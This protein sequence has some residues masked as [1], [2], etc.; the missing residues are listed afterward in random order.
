MDLSKT[1]AE[2]VR[3]NDG[4]T[5][6]VVHEV[7]RRFSH[8]RRIPKADL[9]QTARIGMIEAIRDFDPSRGIKDTTWVSKRMTWTIFNAYGGLKAKDPAWTACP[10]ADVPDG[11]DEHEG[12]A[13]R[14]E[15]DLASRRVRTAL[16]E[17]AASTPSGNRHD[18]FNMRAVE[19]I[20]LRYGIGR[21]A[22]TLEDAAR[23][24][25]ITRERVRQVCMHA[26]SE[27]RNAT[28]LLPY[29]REEWLRMEARR[30]ADQ[31]RLARMRLVRPSRSDV[32]F[33]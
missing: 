29:R 15:S 33:S 14:D 24:I 1:E 18:N 10:V 28:A 26:E 2:I 8:Y 7:Q 11:R 27:L 20:R 30:A 19:V 23:A 4:L 31:G 16:D 6:S 17:L 12:V 9:W 25:G 3:E 22:C 5:R 13:E 32:G 21:P